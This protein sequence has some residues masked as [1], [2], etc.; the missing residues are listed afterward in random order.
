MYKHNK[1]Y[2]NILVLLLLIVGFRFAFSQNSAGRQSQ[3]IIMDGYGLEIEVDMIP[4]KPNL[5]DE[6][7]LRCTM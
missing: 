5:G 4:D 7:E 3:M 1:K 2:L 6:V